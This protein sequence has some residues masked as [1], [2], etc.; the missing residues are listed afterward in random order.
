[1]TRLESGA[2]QL[3]RE[4]H[5]LEEV[6]GAALSRLEGRSAGRPRRRRSVPATCRWCRR[7]RADRAGAGQPAR[8]RRQVHAARAARSRSSRSRDRPKPCRRGRRPRARACAPGEEQRV[9]EKFYRGRAGRGR[10]RRPRAWPSAAA[11]S[12]RTAGGSGPRTVPAAARR[13]ASRS[14]WRTPHAP[15]RR[16]R[17]LTPSPD[18]TAA[19][20]RRPDRGRA[21]DPPLPA[22]DA[23]RPGLP[24]ARGG[25]RRGR[26]RAGGAVAASRTLVILDLGL[27]DMDGLEVIRRLREWTACRSSCSPRA[28]RS[29][30]GGRRSTPAPTTT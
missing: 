9:F 24:P 29:G 5:P 11:S 6:V 27:P 21:A 4:W 13:S 17:C 20:R 15:A 25:D 10:R 19:P 2:L 18:S 14:R 22:R 12:R 16:R 28:A 7:R 30:Q 26:A 3:N 1:M 23:G 8:E